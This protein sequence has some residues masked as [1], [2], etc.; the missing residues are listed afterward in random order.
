MAPK[1]PQDCPREPQEPSRAPSGR[2][3]RTTLFD[4]R[5]VVLRFWHFRLFSP[6]EAR[7]RLQRPPT[8]PQQGT[9]GG[10]QDGP[11]TS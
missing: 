4:C 1:L 3:A 10:L 2:P 9:R 8:S 5:S 6:P 11:P 7:R